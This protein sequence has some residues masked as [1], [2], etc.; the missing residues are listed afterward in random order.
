MPSLSQHFKSYLKLSP[1]FYVISCL[2]GTLFFSVFSFAESTST[3]SS[4]VPEQ[5]GGI[6]KEIKNFEAVYK[7]RF[8]GIGVTAIRKLET[9]PNGHQQL[10]FTADSWLAKLSETSEFTWVNDSRVQP[11]LY[12]YTRTGLGRDRKAVLNFDWKQ[13]KVVNDVENKP[14]TMTIPDSA[15]DKLSYQLQIQSDLINGKELKPYEIA[16][17]GRIKTYEFE[18]TG[19]EKISTPAGDFKTIKVKRLHSNDKKRHTFF[20]LAPAWNYLMVKVEQQDGSQSYEI[21]LNSATINGKKVT[22]M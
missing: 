15:F 20:W 11:E 12:T 8:R 21:D 5:N 6:N 22:G 16:D 1:Y 14:W 3:P 18:I 7:A 17:G 10:S 13:K 2:L 4:T 19:E 9:L